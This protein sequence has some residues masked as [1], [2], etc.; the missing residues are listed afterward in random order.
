MLNFLCICASLERHRSTEG[1]F[2]C[3]TFISPCIL[4]LGGGWTEGVY[5]FCRFYNEKRK[6][7][8]TKTQQWWL[9]QR[10]FFG[11]WINII[12][13]QAMETLAF[14]IQVQTSPQCSGQYFGFPCVDVR[15]L[16]RMGS[17]LNLDKA[18]ELQRGGRKEASYLRSG[19]CYRMEKK[20][21]VR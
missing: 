21:E 19:V 1:T 10:I 11:E 18:H 2:S 8:P 3:L 16:G 7:P 15:W 20:V 4:L 9:Y 6:F 12:L 17:C 13:L 14:S 5:G